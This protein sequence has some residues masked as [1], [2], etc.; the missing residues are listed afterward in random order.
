L[1]DF[2]AK[3]TPNHFDTPSRP[4]HGSSCT[5]RKCCWPRWA[6][7]WLLRTLTAIFWIW[8]MMN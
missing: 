8:R 6:V 5:I 3:R 1:I 7:R 2:C 4:R